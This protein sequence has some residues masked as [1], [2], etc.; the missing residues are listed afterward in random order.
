MMLAETTASAADRAAIE[1]RV[2]A[3]A[4]LV[5]LQAFEPLE[6]LFAKEVVLDYTSLFGGEVETLAATEL[7][8][9][10]AGL[11]PGFD[12]T[13]HAIGEVTVEIDGDQAKA[14]AD[15][16]GTHWLDGEIWGVSGR[17]AYRF[18]RIEGEW[19][20]TAMTLIATGE[21]GDRGLI[22]K[23]MARASE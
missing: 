22:D 17:Y 12:R 14:G 19:R 8:A 9:R 23:A 4:L 10:W 20:I 7:M 11:L 6:A 15:V 3:V 2:E 5:D 1:T 16:I 21:A 13:R 18:S